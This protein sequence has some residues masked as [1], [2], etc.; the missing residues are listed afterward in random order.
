MTGS[1][2]S[3]SL[4]KMLQSAKNVLEQGAKTQAKEN[5]EEIRDEKELLKK[6]EEIDRESGLGELFKPAEY[7]A[8]TDEEINAAAQNEMALKF[9]GDREKITDALV[10]AYLR[11]EEQKGDAYSKA[12]KD[13]EKSEIG[14]GQKLSQAEKNAVKKGIARSSIIEEKKKEIEKEKAGK[15]SQI[16]QK[17]KDELDEIDGKI[18]AA[19]NEKEKALSEFDL[20]YAAALEKEINALKKERDKK[21]DETIK[22]NNELKEKEKKYYGSAEG[23]ARLLKVQEE[24]LA[25]AKK[26]YDR[27]PKS[28]ALEEFV[29]NENMKSHLGPYYAYMLNYI[30]NRQDF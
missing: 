20:K 15:I 29:G 30:N 25:A 8:P 28:K 13:K 24:K 2:I 18:T 7:D 23:A 5:E 12:E 1:I 14:Y 21:I 11:L 9:S 27:M 16:E 4:K 3:E 10:K 6:F 17:L 19:E 22:Y 26:Y